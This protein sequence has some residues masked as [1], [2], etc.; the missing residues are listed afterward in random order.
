MRNTVSIEFLMEGVRNWLL[1]MSS[2]K[3]F[4]GALP[5]NL[6]RCFMFFKKLK[7]KRSLTSSAEDTAEQFQESEIFEKKEKESRMLKHS[8]IVGKYNT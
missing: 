3:E 2:V 6:A 1:P 5:A 7:A 4:F 8:K